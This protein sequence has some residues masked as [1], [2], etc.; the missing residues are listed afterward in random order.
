MKALQLTAYKELAVVDMPIP[1]IDE[2]SLLIRVAAC[3]ICGSDIHG[4][5]GSTGR[6]LPPLVMGHE[7]AG[8]VERVGAD[9][10]RFAIGDRVTF[11]STIS[12][13]AC[14]FCLSGRGNLCERRQVVGVACDEFHRDGAFAEYVA[15]PELACYHLPD[16]FPFEHA[17]LIEAV[18]VAVHAVARTPLVPEATTVVVGAGMIG[19]LV[20]QALRAA[21]AE[22]II[23][24][25]RVPDRLALAERSGAT[26]TIDA[27]TTD[28]VAAVAAITGGLMADHSFEVVGITPTITTAVEVLDRGGTVTLVGNLDPTVEVPLQKLVNREIAL[29]G[30]CASNGE[31]PTSIELMATGAIDVRAL[32]SATAPLEDGP[33]WF[34]RLY[35]GE[36]GLMKV[37][38]T[39]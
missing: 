23:A 21:G 19:T 26:H 11:D 25:D 7:A 24:I 15:V 18:S 1:A 6:R 10:T 9:V 31:Y 17:A 33:A 37:V 22:R 12:C 28:P 39:P 8:V 14:R 16:S 38:L 3:G 2:R 32:I 13:G 5:D 27:S 34:E 30:S 4:F 36:P 35:A 29:L 20:V